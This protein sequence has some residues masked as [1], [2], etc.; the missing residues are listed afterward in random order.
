MPMRKKIYNYLPKDELAEIYKSWQRSDPEAYK[1]IGRLVKE[2]EQLHKAAD[3]LKKIYFLSHGVE[4][5]KVTPAQA[6]KIYDAAVTRK[7]RRLERVA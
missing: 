3:E 2:I 7:E 6:A 4:V 1:L 5:E